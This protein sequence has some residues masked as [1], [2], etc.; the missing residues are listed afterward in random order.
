LFGNHSKKISQETWLAISAINFRFC[1]SLSL[2]LALVSSFL[3]ATSCFT[4]SISSLLVIHV[5]FPKTYGKELHRKHSQNSLSL[6]VIT[7]SACTL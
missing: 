1:S 6:Q 4:P 7:Q 3:F 2:S 5:A